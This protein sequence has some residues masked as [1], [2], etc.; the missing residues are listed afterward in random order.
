MRTDIAELSL[1]SVSCS[2]FADQHMGTAGLRKKVRVF[3]QP[4]YLECFIQA[5]LD[6]LQ[7]PQGASLVLGGDGRYFNN[8]ALQTLIC[9]TAAAGVRQL[10]IGQHG[11][12]STPAASNLIRKRKAQ[13]G[14]L[15]TA[16]H[17]PG[18]PDGD[19]GIKFNMPTG[20]QAPESVTNA[21]FEAS[22]TLQ[23][24]RIAELPAIDL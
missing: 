14:F 11:L 15:L 8:E 21:V 18:G 19:F 13:G 22:R 23:G 5:V 20:G 4:H 3:Q 1:R 2:P 6:T 16:S 24:Y 12:L 17:N 7:L 9:L 10:I